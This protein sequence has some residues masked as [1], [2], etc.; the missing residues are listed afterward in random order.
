MGGKVVAYSLD[1]MNREVVFLVQA[2][3]AQISENFLY[4]ALTPEE[5]ALLLTF[6]LE[7]E[8]ESDRESIAE[9]ETNFEV[10][11]DHV[12]EFRVEIKVA[13]ENPSPPRGGRLIWVRKRDWSGM[14]L[15]AEE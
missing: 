10:M 14:E 5:D 2:C 6:A 8:N 4:V 9:I 11:H 1:A 12:P 7:S 13:P 15:P 3:L